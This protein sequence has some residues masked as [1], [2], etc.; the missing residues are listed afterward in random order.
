[1]IDEKLWYQRGVLLWSD[2]AGEKCKMAV[3]RD[4]VFW[5]LAGVAI[6]API[7]GSLVW[8]HRDRYSMRKSNSNL[9]SKW[10]YSKS[11]SSK[12]IRIIWNSGNQESLLWYKN[13]PFFFLI[14]WVPDEWFFRN[15]FVSFWLQFGIIARGKSHFWLS[16][17][18]KTSGFLPL[19]TPILDFYHGLLNMVLPDLAYA[20]SYT[21]LSCSCS[22]SSS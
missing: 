2:V 3:R 8:Q 22:C 13:I 20:S 7:I 14:S 17:T 18:Q 6:L 15:W 11:H 19:C 12:F 5:S 4:T 9:Q 10:A 21:A 1:M 16:D